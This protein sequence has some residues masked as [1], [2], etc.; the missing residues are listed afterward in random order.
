MT[1]VNKTTGLNELIK[2]FDVL[3]ENF[4]SLIARA[5]PGAAIEKTKLWKYKKALQNL[6][7]LGDS[8]LASLLG[9]V[10]KYCAMNKVFDEHSKIVIP[11]DKLLEL[12]GGRHVIHDV[13]ENYNGTFFELSIA[14]RFAQRFGDAAVID[15]TT[16]CDVILN[17]EFAVEC[18]YLHSVNKFRSNISD[19]MA[20]LDER[21]D[22]GFA[23]VGVVALDLSN[24]MDS[25][26]IQTF[27]QLVFDSFAA[28]YE[29]IISSRGYIAHDLNSDGVVK[30]VLQDRNFEK[31]MGA[32]I[33]H[34]AESTFHMNFTKQEL[35]K[36]DYRKMAIVYQTSNYL[37]FHYQENVVPAP[38]R[39]L[40][41]YI[42]HGLPEEGYTSLQRFF[43]KLAVG[44]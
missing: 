26:K 27:G 1:I 17:G 2:E 14:V 5:K 12:L 35:E 24:L 43:H 33:G 29:E 30:S 42:H 3:I 21:I 22:K 41:Y 19:A 38:F 28:S 6:N 10:S 44:I 15:M 40:N 13:A 23:K 9:L 11:D 4:R 39:T 32:F 34:L 18:K 7:E 25:E 20:Q 8:E 16:D 37:C 36:L 31:I